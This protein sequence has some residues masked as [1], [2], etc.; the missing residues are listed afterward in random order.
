MVLRRED[1][2]PAFVDAFRAGDGLALGEVYARWSS[3]VYSL[4]LRSLGDVNDAEEVT[5]QVF[6]AAW[7]SRHTFDPAR[8]RLPSWL[9]GIAR[10]KIADAHGARA[11]QA[12]LRT[13]VLAKT[14]VEDTIEPADV[15]ARLV[16]LDELAHLDAVPARIIRMAFYDDLTHTQIAERLGMPLGT[17]KSHIRRSLFKLRERLELV[18]DAP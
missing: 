17:V 1:D 18:S 4:A 9:V 6:T 13:Q 14:R 12:R 15:A 5:Q 16:L 11:R 10:N 8:A 3:L 2:S 7:T